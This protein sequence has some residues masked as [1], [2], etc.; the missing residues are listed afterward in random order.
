MRERECAFWKSSLFPQVLYMHF[1]PTNDIY[2][3]E[4]G[5]RINHHLRGPILWWTCKM[6]DFVNFYVFTSVLSKVTSIF[7]KFT[8]ILGKF[9]SIFYRFTSVLDK[10]ISV[11]GKF[12]SVF[13]RFT[14]V[15]DKVTSILGKFTS[16]INYTI[17]W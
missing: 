8:N 17:R 10:I 16:V 14:N 9:T 4:V 5:E 7:D 2:D 15:L 6:V 3:R 13:Y 12:I 11:L 1:H